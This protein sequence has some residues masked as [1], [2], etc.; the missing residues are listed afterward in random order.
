MKE[1]TNLRFREAQSRLLDAIRQRIRNG[2]W[3]ERG[4]AKLIGVSQPHVHNVLKG[5]R[6]L[7]TEISDLILTST[8]QTILDLCTR[9]ELERQLSHPGGTPSRVYDIV[10]LNSPIGPG[11]PWPRGVEVLN[12]ITLPASIH[13]PP[14]MLVA[15]R[16][17]PDPRM[18]SL[19][20]GN[21]LAVL[22]TSERVRESLTPDG[23]YAVSRGEEC[24]LRQLRPGAGRLYLVAADSRHRPL[25]WEPLSLSPGGIAASLRGKAIWLGKETERGLP[26]HQRG[27]FLDDAI[28]S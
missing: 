16:L 26:P 11:H 12:R 14:E 7:T 8:G 20:E 22:N 9:A 19:I 17:A 5:A 2:D 21:D 4:F 28:S 15:A 23:L 27:R 1:L 3:T 13:G 18:E 24:V 6:A 10:F 25:D